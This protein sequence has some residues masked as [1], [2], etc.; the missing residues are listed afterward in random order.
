MSIGKSLGPF[1]IFYSY[2]IGVPMYILVIWHIFPRFGMLNRKKSGNTGL[3][4][5]FVFPAAHCV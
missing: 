2:I 4:L 3:L 5:P 1:G